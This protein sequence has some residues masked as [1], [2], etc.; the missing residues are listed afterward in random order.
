[1]CLHETSAHPL[2]G[3]HESESPAGWAWVTRAKV[4]PFSVLGECLSISLPQTQSLLHLQLSSPWQG[5]RTQLPGAQDQG[6]WGR[7]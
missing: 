6:H 7:E 1:M 5:G 3:A 2:G 4:K